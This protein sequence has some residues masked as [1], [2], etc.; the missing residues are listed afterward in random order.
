VFC[1]FQAF[2]PQFVGPS[3]TIFGKAAV[4][5]VCN[6]L[7][8]NVLYWTVAECVLHGFPSCDIMCS[9]DGTCVVHS[10]SVGIADYI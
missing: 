2:L 9:V 7:N 4:C 10:G 6:A 5:F 1:D 3:G 8:I